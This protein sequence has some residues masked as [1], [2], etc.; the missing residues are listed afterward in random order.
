MDSTWKLK[1]WTMFATIVLAIYALVPTFFGWPQTRQDLE[2]QKKE[3]PWYY[4][5]FPEKGLNL[6]LDLRGGI[7]IEMDVQV[8]EGLT[9][10]LDILSQ[11]L[12]RDL[13]KQNVEP[14]TSVQDTTHQYIN[15][16]FKNDADLQAAVTLFEKDY[17]TALQRDKI[18]TT[19]PSTLRF[20]LN[21]QYAKQVRQ[22]ILS[23]AVQAVRNR[24]DRYGL[25]EPNVQRQGD[26]RLV[27]ELPG[28]KDPERAIKIIQQAGKL[29]FKLVS[30][31]LSPTQVGDLVANARKDNNL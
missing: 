20:G 7:Y 21:A 8:E 13:K 16:T 5:V 12:I 15:M 9:T 28:A 19:G 10:K 25:S 14:T 29:E 2:A 6:G 27:V 26:T 4:N 24:I 18:A 31:K 23:Q 1:A 17:K 11:D 3:I 30:N 22:D